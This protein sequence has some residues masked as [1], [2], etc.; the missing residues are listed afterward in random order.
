M[1]DNKLGYQIGVSCTMI[2]FEV[3]FTMF[4]NRTKIVR[5]ATHAGFDAQC[6]DVR[7]LEAPMLWKQPGAS[8]TW[9]AMLYAKK[10]PPHS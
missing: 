6:P 4:E 10:H 5:E 3:I 2:L 7:C 9:K 1:L 8:T